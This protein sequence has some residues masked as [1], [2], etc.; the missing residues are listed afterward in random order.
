MIYFS[1]LDP[2]WATAPLGK[3][4]F[5]IGRWGCLETCVTM[6]FNW[7][8]S[9]TATPATM[10][11]KLTFLPTGDLDWKSLGNVG[12]KLISRIRGREDQAVIMEALKHPRKVCFLQV[13]KAHWLFLIG[14]KL[15]ILGYR[16]VDP[17]TGKPCYTSKYNNNITGSAVVTEL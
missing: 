5:L 11:P 8:Y 6:A 15:P 14:R 2:N 9:S 7:L 10:E 13:N 4:K 3:T 16:V 12:M 17:L 1:Q